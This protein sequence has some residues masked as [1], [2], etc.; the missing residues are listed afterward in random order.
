MIQ[1]K[2]KN[3]CSDRNFYLSLLQIFDFMTLFNPM[4][5]FK[6][7]SIYCLIVIHLFFAC[8]TSG[9]QTE[10]L[11]ETQ[12]EH[13]HAQD[14]YY[15]CPMHPEIRLEEQG[16]CPLCKM[17]L[18]FVPFDA[19]Q[20]ALELHWN[21]EILQ[22][23]EAGTLEITPKRLDKD[24]EKVALTIAHE[25][26]MHLILVSE[27][28]S[29]F[30][31]VHPL[32]QQDS[33]FLLTIIPPQLS[34]S[35]VPQEHQAMFHFAGKYILFS[36][37][38]PVNAAKQLD[39]HEFQIAENPSL[40]SKKAH[41]KEKLKPNLTHISTLF[42]TELT[43]KKW[44]TNCPQ[45]LEFSIFEHQPNQKGKIVNPQDFDN[46]LG[47]KAHIVIIDESTEEFIH[48][49]PSVKH[50]K[51]F[52]EALFNKAG[53]YKIWLQY[54]WEGQLTVQHFVIEVQTKSQDTVYVCP[55]NCEKKNYDC[56]GVCPVCKMELA[57]ISKPHK[58]ETQ[59]T[60]QHTH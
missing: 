13:H 36:D 49:H 8:Q 55:M 33:V 9:H 47:E 4:R 21:P 52:T 51:I 46:Y 2:N 41:Q 56:S 34:L 57:E 11:T 58:T 53:L 3:I 24:M 25:K 54:Q 42:H 23:H 45:T 28:L 48:A 6:L 31:H 15:T 37:Y 18:I 40:K 5:F 39:R 35:V 59:A 26:K 1:K 44:H 30:Q 27:D 14:G 20:Y 29:D 50:Q 22:E 32:E 10:H 19:G 17:D 60:H 12:H 43:E 16:I 38:L 7:N